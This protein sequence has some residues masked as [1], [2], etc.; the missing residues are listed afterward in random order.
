MSS[1]TEKQKEEYLK[2]SSVCPFCKSSNIEGGPVEINGNEADQRVSCNEC[3]KSWI[4]IYTL[5]EVIPD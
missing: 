5:T 3:N 4:D 2:D 1:L